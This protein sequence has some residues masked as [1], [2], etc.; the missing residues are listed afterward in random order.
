MG[1]QLNRTPQKHRSVVCSR[2]LITYIKQEI[3]TLLPKVN[4]LNFEKVLLKK[5]LEA[6]G[7]ADI[8][9]TQLRSFSNSV[10]EEQKYLLAY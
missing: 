7:L 9:F 10:K 6:Q 3:K 1:S 5:L 4:N 2:R 8:H